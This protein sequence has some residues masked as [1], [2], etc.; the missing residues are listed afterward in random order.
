MPTLSR[1]SVLAGSIALPASMGVPISPPFK[2]SEACGLDAVVS[3]AEAWT[4]ARE[5]L[6]A[7]QLEWQRW[8]NDLFDKARRM[9]VGCD[10]ACKSNWPEA[11]A[12]RALDLRMTATYA[13]LETLA[14]KVRQMRAATISAAVAKIQLG[15]QVQGAY[16]WQDHALE[17]VQDGLVELRKMT[18]II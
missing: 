3:H 2:A 1:R 12:M 10:R 4:A 18:G 16:D 17:L 11:Q 13:Q 9:K 8:E 15:L 14:G 7:M 6:T 5:N